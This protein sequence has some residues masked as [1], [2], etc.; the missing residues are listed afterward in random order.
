M[1]KNI[2]PFQNKLIARTEKEKLL[3]QNSKVFWFT[4]LSGAG[5]STL[6]LGLEK[7][8][9][10][11]GYLSLV[12][13]GDNIRSGINKNLGFS[14]EDRLENIRRIAEISKLIASSGVIVICAFVSPTN[15]VRTLA[16]NIIGKQDFNEIFVATALEICEQRDIKGLYKKARAGKIKNFTGIDAPFEEPQNPDFLIQTKNS[17]PAESIKK[18]YKFVLTKIQ[19]I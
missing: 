18:V 12:L 6:A 3:G 11:N 15:K 9:H 16:K 13:D 7:K 17:I 14:P 10:E 4:G 1:Q 8:L 5:K 2:F 19:K